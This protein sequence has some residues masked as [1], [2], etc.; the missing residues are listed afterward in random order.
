M[1]YLPSA[2][3]TPP[4]IC[5]LACLC[6]SCRKRWPTILLTEKPRAMSRIQAETQPGIQVPAGPANRDDLKG[7]TSII[8]VGI[9]GAEF[10][11]LRPRGQCET[12]VVL[13][14]KPERSRR[15]DD[16][17]NSTDKSRLSCRSN[18]R[19]HATRRKGRGLARS[20]AISELSVA[21]GRSVLIE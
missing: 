12:A 19:E 15:N 1:P 4:S 3:R 13:H 6:T 10:N 17:R 18:Q 9:I 5:Q 11:S 2:P 16:A 8:Q 7:G 14:P 20:R 21:V